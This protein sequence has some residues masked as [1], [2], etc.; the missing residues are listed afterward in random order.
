MGNGRGAVAGVDGG[1][2]VGSCTKALGEVG[3]AGGADVTLVEQKWNSSTLQLGLSR[4]AQPA[5]TVGFK[6]T[7]T[8]MNRVSWTFVIASGPKAL[9]LVYVWACPARAERAGAST[10]PRVR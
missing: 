1:E 2:G 10:S 7:A 8:P 3:D 4:H 5:A 6:H 9:R